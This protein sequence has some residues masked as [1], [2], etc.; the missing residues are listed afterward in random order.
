MILK[1]LWNNKIQK[2]LSIYSK[3]TNFLEETQNLD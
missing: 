1:Q 2:D 3:E